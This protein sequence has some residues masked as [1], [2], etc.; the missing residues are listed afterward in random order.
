MVCYQL[1]QQKPL[2]SKQREQAGTRGHHAQCTWPP[3]GPVPQAPTS[4]PNYPVHTACTEA[5]RTQGCLLYNKRERAH[6][7]GGALRELAGDSRNS[8]RSKGLAGASDFV[9]S[10]CIWWARGSIQGPRPICKI[11]AACSC[12]SQDPSWPEQR[13]QAGSTGHCSAHLATPP[14]ATQAR[15]LSAK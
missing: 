13:E 9:P 3:S 12:T 14:G 2:A 5:T 15:W 11:S 10:T 1:D 8:P 7:E 6:R 4:F